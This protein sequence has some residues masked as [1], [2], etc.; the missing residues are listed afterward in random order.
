VKEML[1]QWHEPLMSICPAS[2]PHCAKNKGSPQALLPAF[3][4]AV[5]YSPAM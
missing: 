5:A 1:V 3:R 4:L 2:P